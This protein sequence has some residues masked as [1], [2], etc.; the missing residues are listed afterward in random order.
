MMNYDDT[1]MII[2][3]FNEEKNIGHLI[4]LLLKILPNVHIIVSDD[5]SKDRTQE[6]VCERPGKNIILLDRKRKP[7]HGLTI[8]VMDAILKCR[9]KFFVVIDADFQHP[10]DKIKEIVGK[11]RDRYED[12]TADDNIIHLENTDI[13]P[14]NK[15]KVLGADIVIGNRIKVKGDWGIDRVIISK[16]AYIL[17]ALRLAAKG[18]PK[19]DL[20]SG[21][22]GGKTYIVK[23]IILKHFYKFEFKG[24]KVLFDILKYLPNNAR[25]DKVDYEFGIRKAGESKLSKKVVFY[26]FRSLFK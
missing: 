16:T 3:T 5:G 4:D 7:V 23:E 2:P 6:I 25:V 11:L 14:D 12:K 19:Y 17:G 1:T 21:F 13:M 10:P 18:F 8:S 20:V 15:E 24:Y 26:Y 9:T 22:F